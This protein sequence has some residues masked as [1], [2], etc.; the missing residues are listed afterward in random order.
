MRVEAPIRR[1]R[2]EFEQT[3]RAYS[4]DLYRYAYWLSRD[5][6]TAE[7]LVQECFAR[8]WA[9]WVDLKDRAAAKPWLIA[10]LRNERA[11]MFARKAIPLADEDVQELEM[12]VHSNEGERLDLRRRL[13]RLPE[14]YR[15]PLLL[16]VLG[17]YSCAEIAAMLS[18]SE[19]AVMTRLTR[20]RQALRDEGAR[21]ALRKVAT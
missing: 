2:D 11:R 14:A 9:A 15:E 18:T 12:P 8:A 4:A 16:Q 6:F 20:A 3:V 19:G 1:Q 7:E 13:E 17:G 21:P 10:I 5:R